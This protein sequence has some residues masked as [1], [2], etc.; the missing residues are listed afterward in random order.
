[1]VIKKYDQNH[2]KIK[3]EIHTFVKLMRIIF[4]IFFSLVIF[5]ASFQ[6]SLFY[7]DYKVNRDFY[8][9]HCINKAKPELDCNGKCQV[10]QQSEKSQNPISEIKY[11]F[12]FNIVPTKNIELPK[13]KA[14]FSEKIQINFNNSTE[15][16]L[17]GFHKILPQPP[18]SLA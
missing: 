1:M 16:I 4:S 7:F 2:T 17:K 11:A 18:Q 9:A 13:P 8:E 14:N 6:N 15:N 5:A 12:E 3:D 10:R